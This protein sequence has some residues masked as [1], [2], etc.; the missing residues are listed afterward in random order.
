MD[1]SVPV[2][3]SASDPAGTGGAS[4]SKAADEAEACAAAKYVADLIARGEAVEI[5]TK[6]R[7]ERSPLPPGVTHEIVP[8]EDGEQPTVRRRRYSAF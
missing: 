4:K 5:D 8:G 6:K 3:K 2:T 7:A 1:E